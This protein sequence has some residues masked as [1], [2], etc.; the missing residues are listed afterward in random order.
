MLF[1]VNV[2]YMRKFDSNSNFFLIRR[3][4]RSFCGKRWR[5][6]LTVT[7]PQLPAVEPIFLLHW[8]SW[9]WLYLVSFNDFFYHPILM[10]WCTSTYTRFPR[11]ACF[12]VYQ[13]IYE[14]KDDALS[15]FSKCY[16]TPQSSESQETTQALEH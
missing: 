14:S 12:W 9:G 13:N 10:M 6:W 7:Y 8:Q 16:C 2:L 3:D 11:N 5:K 15:Y 4:S 1:A